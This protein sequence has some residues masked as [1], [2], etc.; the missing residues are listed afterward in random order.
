MHEEF[1]ANYPYRLVQQ[2]EEGHISHITLYGIGLWFSPRLGSAD[3]PVGGCLEI[4]CVWRQHSLARGSF[5]LLYRNKNTSHGASDP[6]F[7]AW[8]C[9]DLAT[10]L[11]DC[12]SELGMLDSPN[13][14]ALLVS[15]SSSLVDSLPKAGEGRMACSLAKRALLGQ[16]GVADPHKCL[17][18]PLHAVTCCY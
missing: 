17:S 8:A 12:L 1:S 5:S 4:G 10:G 15:T 18:S 14:T 16:L 2:L 6:S 3:L 13:G 7:V 11:A 9:R